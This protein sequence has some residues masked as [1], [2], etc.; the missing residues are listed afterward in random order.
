MS[1][2]G[3]VPKLE[4]ANNNIQEVRPCW[5]RTY[6]ALVSVYYGV[7]ALVHNAHITHKTCTSIS[8]R[9]NE[10]TEKLDHIGQNQ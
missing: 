9:A 3:N 2:P 6:N 8:F 4:T 5:D 10:Y 7:S 1:A